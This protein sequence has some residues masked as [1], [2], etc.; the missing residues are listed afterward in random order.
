[1]Q[2]LNF[3]KIGKTIP[4]SA[5]YIGRQ[6]KQYGL[7]RSK[8]ANPFPITE[9]Q[10]RDTV[11]KMYRSWLW[12]KIKLKEITVQELLDLDSKDLV[13]YCSPHPCHGDVLVKAVEWAKTQPVTTKEFKDSYWNW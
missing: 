6:N 4:D 11:I 5:V 3:Y 7:E 10:D 8:F 12:N 2:V 13:C 1:M 9:Y